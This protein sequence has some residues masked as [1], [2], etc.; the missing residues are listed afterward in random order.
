MPYHKQGCY[1]AFDHVEEVAEKYKRCRKM[2]SLILSDEAIEA[3]EMYCAHCGGRLRTSEDPENEQPS[4]GR[5]I[6]GNYYP[7]QR[8]LVVMHY[9]CS[10]EK[11]M[12]DI[13]VHEC[14]AQPPARTEGVMLFDESYHLV[15]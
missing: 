7:R 13:I 15:A 9:Y 4:G 14:V 1:D 3:T 8:V 5:S 6:R 10:W 12:N 2:K 11:L